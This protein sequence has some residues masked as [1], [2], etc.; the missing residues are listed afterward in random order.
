M[1]NTLWGLGFSIVDSRRRKLTKRL[2][3]TP[4]SRT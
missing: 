4:M 1:S 3:A 2:I